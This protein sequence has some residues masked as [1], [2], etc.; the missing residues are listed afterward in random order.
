MPD[1]L[2]SMGRALVSQP[3]A[4]TLAA[5][6]TVSA[7]FLVAPG[8]DLWFSSLFYRSGQFFLGGNPEL[9]VFRR[10]SEVIVFS[11]AGLLIAQVVVKLLRPEAPS[12]VP[13]ASTLFLLSTL[14]LAPG[15]LVNAILK[16]NWGRPRP[17]MIGQF[18]GPFPYVDVWQISDYCVRNCSF[19]S[20]EASSA[21][22]LTA[23][24]FV[25]PRRW[26]V[27]VAVLAGVYAF[28]ISLNRIAFGGHFVSDVILAWGLTFL[29]ILVVRR[30]VLEKPP[31]WLSDARLEAGLTTLG[32]RLR[33]K[34]RS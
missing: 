34:S 8:I 20:G 17:P 2:S 21:I 22:W 31:T 33:G 6:V 16:S 15:I 25:V 7:I 23:L 28:L 29:V 10:S 14:A 19:V 32:R 9:V 5:I 11:I 26:R 24:A 18:G 30:V 4:V 27:P 3:I 1:S 13:P 12:L